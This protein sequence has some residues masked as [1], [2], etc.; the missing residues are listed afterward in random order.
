[1]NLMIP[2]LNTLRLSDEDTV[3]LLA[4]TAQH[5]SGALKK[6]DQVML[7]SALRILCDK[8]VFVILFLLPTLRRSF[9]EQVLLVSH[10]FWRGPGDEGGARVMEC[11]QRAVR[12]ASGMA[13][14]QA[15]LF[16]DILNEYLY[17]FAQGNEQVTTTYI[18]AVL[19]LAS[20]KHAEAEDVSPLFPNTIKYLQRMRKEQPDKY[21]AIK[22]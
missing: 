6:G 15:S 13:E 14:A 12:I 3:T 4:K 10:L 1:M 11:M 9:T 17:Y 7:V 2:T 5:C 18:N 19:E 8:C 16:A 22:V 20:S 21:G